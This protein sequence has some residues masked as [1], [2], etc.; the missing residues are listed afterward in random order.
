MSAEH[1]SE[2]AQEGTGASIV[3]AHDGRFTKLQTWFWGFIGLAAVTGSFTAASTLYQLNLTVARV[4]DS[5]ALAA[6]QIKDHEDRLRQV[7]RDVSVIEGKVFRGVRGYEE[8]VTPRGPNA[9]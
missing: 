2:K 8:P 3:M 4:A 5:N 1:D 9:R 7:E 6:A